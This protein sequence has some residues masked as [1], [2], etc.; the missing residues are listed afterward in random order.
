MVA[1]IS[2]IFI[3][4]I[5]QASWNKC[6]FVMWTNYLPVDIKPFQ[7]NHAKHLNHIS[8]D[9]ISYKKILLLEF[10]F[11]LCKQQKDVMLPGHC[12]SNTPKLHP[13]LKNCN[14]LQNLFSFGLVNKKSFNTACNHTFLHFWAANMDFLIILRCSVFF[15]LITLQED[16]PLVKFHLCR[17]CTSLKNKALKI[18]KFNFSAILWNLV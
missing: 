14:F 15:L 8:R 2:K 4:F 12:S 1:K 17:I 11:P 10:G 9:L 16:F 5:L 6:I 13:G 3:V 7:R 18:I